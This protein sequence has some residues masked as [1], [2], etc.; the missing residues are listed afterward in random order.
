M[1]NI[2]WN[3]L[4]SCTPDSRN[5]NLIVH[6]CLHPIGMWS[7]SPA[8]ALSLC[9]SVSLSPSLVPTYEVRTLYAKYESPKQNKFRLF[10]FNITQQMSHDIKE[11]CRLES[12]SNMSCKYVQYFARYGDMLSK[13]MKPTAN[14]IELDYSVI[15][16]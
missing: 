2:S 15:I 8:P 16:R 5:P 4:L 12:Y 13:H 6:V 10:D 9:H 1:A 14:I 7:C 3:I 11:K